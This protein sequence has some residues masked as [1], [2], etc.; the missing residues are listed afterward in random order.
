MGV[1]KT[2]LE[3]GNGVDYPK[4]GERVAIHY[5]GC[6]Y[7]P[8]KE[9]EHFMGADAVPPLATPIGVG[10]LIKGWDQGVPQMSLGEK[11]IL[12]ISPDFGY[13]AQ[14]FPGLIPANSQLVFE[15]KLVSIGTKSI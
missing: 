5:R 2:I 14:G 11:A 6:L 9:A 3:N 15:V 8:S 12:T 4:V 1:E 10:R 7:D 13:G